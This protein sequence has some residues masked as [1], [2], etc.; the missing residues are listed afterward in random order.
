MR[1]VAKSVNLSPMT[2][3]RALRD[4]KTVSSK[5][6]EL[7][8]KAATDLG[9][10]Y[11]GTAQA[12][13]TQKSGFV[14]I[15][16]PSVNNANF[17]ETFRG[18]SNGLDG[19]GIQILLGA[20]NYQLEKEHELVM[21]LLA[22]KPE[23]IVLTGSSHLSQ[24]RSVLEIAQIPIIEIWDLPS[25]PLGHVVGFSN[26]NAMAQVVRHLAS[27]GR[28]K[29]AFVGASEGT[30]M[31]GA[32]RRD[33]AVSAAEELNLPEITMIDAGRAPVSMRQ[34]SEVIMQS[35]NGITRFDALV[36]VSDPVAFGVLNACR[37]LGLSVP[38]DI[39]VTGFGNFDLAKVS[40]PQ[41]TTVNVHANEIGT[42]VA[43]VLR[44]IFDEK[45]DKRHID[46]GFELA[47]GE[48]T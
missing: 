30:D 18:L 3:S 33:G 48:T 21:Q 15:T 37:K 44:D 6:R 13:R 19:L 10:V 11:D 8:K 46:V 43:D 40:S 25:D 4:D 1:D 24:T 28:R 35:G 41:I 5:T 23:A 38:D 42:K 34:G 26:A 36:C 7:V 39:A 17:A 47:I 32:A 31:R 20:T 22:R 12:F 29:L 9:Y 14:A 27:T 45:A 16:L 2:V